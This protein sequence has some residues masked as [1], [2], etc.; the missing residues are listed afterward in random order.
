MWR[1]IARAKYT[2]L[3]RPIVTRKK[4]GP[5]MNLTKEVP[6]P[7]DDSEPV[8]NAFDRIAT[9]NAKN[10]RMEVKNCEK[11]ELGDKVDTWLG[12]FRRA[13]PISGY[14][15]KQ[16]IEDKYYNALKARRSVYN[17]ANDGINPEWKEHQLSEHKLGMLTWSAVVLTECMNCNILY[18]CQTGEEGECEWIHNIRASARIDDPLELKLLAIDGRFSE[19]GYKGMVN[20]RG[21]KHVRYLNVSHAPFFNDHA[22]ARLHYIDNSLEYLDISGTDVTLGGLSYLRLLRNLKWVNLS[23]MPKQSDME[24]YSAFIAEVLPPSCQVV[25]NEDHLIE[26]DLLPSGDTHMQH[27]QLTPDDVAEMFDLP[28]LGE[29]VSESRSAAKLRRRRML[30]NYNDFINT[31]KINRAIYAKS[32]ERLPPLL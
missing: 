19:L 13:N 27:K 23:S 2:E 7:I 15:N 11:T 12:R 6:M 24:T 18:E 26:R 20:F 5:R 10:N 31:R 22:M 16:M 30:H 4:W 25:F 29:S 21:H 14:R 28:V 1:T 32:A 9:W 3:P 17:H 8:W